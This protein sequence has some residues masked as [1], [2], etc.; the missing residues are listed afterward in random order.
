MSTCEFLAVHHAALPEAELEE[1][2]GALRNAVE[3]VAGHG[4]ERERGA[5]AP[6]HADEECGEAGQQ[7][8]R[9]DQRTHRRAGYQRTSSLAQSL[10]GR[11]HKQR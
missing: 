5:H 11:L 9:G 1:R 8:P 10:L 4:F 2:E 3:A 7:Q 6:I